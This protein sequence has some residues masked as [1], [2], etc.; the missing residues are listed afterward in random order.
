MPSQTPR[1][2]G[3]VVLGLDKPGLEV[4]GYGLEGDKERVMLFRWTEEGPREVEV[5]PRREFVRE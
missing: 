4:E 1:R 3:K 2:D 5:R